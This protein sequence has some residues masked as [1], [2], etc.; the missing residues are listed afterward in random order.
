[1]SVCLQCPETTLKLSRDRAFTW[2]P[3][4]L[5]YDLGWHLYVD[6]RQDLWQQLYVH[7][8]QGQ[9][10]G[11]HANMRQDLRHHLCVDLRYERRHRLCVDLRE[12]LSRGSHHELKLTWE[13]WIEAWESWRD[14]ASQEYGKRLDNAGCCV[15]ICRIPAKWKKILLAH[16]GSW[17][18]WCTNIGDW[19]LE[20]IPV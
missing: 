14:S 19:F 6:L 15:E 7:L 2:I 17:H 18:Q 11:L 4:N 16:C 1:M 13:T 20:A 8:K 5:R 3:L 10:H 9:R 12:D